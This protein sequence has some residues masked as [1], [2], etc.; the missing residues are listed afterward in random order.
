MRFAEQPSEEEVRGKL[1]EMYRTL[2]R[3]QDME[4]FK[5][6]GWVFELSESEWMN[7]YSEELQDQILG[8]VDQYRLENRHPACERYPGPEWP[9]R[10]FLAI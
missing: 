10:F 1:K 8:C 5:V 9:Y 7:K 3:G 4:F 2:L 6:Q